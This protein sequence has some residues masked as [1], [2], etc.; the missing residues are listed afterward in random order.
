MQ[1][2]QWS[3]S[4]SASSLRSFFLVRFPSLTTNQA[5]NKNRKVVELDWLSVLVWN[6]VYIDPFLEAH[7]YNLLQTASGSSFPMI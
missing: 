1:W 2:R 7:K 3:S 4:K 6:V 5:Q